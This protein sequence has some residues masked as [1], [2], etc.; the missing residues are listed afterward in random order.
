MIPKVCERERVVTFRGGLEDE[1]IAIGEDF[2]RA[3]DREITVDG[4]HDARE[5]S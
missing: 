3:D 2:E 5:L 4:D 1:T